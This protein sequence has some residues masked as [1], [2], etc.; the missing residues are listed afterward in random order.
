MEKLYTTKELMS[1]YGVSRNNIARVVRNNKIKRNGTDKG[2]GRPALYKLSSIKKY[3]EKKAK[4]KHCQRVF[5]KYHHYDKYCSK[6]CSKNA[7]NERNNK[8]GHKTDFSYVGDGDF[9]TADRAYQTKKGKEDR[10][11]IMEC[12]VECLLDEL[13]DI[14]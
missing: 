4:C 12:S 7:K 8:T 6:E 2:I 13:G 9:P 14:E 10:K 11:K 3:L 1:K 5:K